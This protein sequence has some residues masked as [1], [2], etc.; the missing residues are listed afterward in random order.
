MKYV[1]CGLCKPKCLIFYFH[2]RIGASLIINLDL[3]YDTLDNSQTV[4]SFDLDR[5]MKPVVV[6]LTLQ[7]AFRISWNINSFYSYSSH[8]QGHKVKDKIR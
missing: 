4:R 8:D 3:L 1:S 5:V 7:E 2:L 6:A